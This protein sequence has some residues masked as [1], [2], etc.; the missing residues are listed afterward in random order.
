MLLQGYLDAPLSPPTDVRPAMKRQV[1]ISMKIYKFTDFLHI[2]LNL[3][4]IYIYIYIPITA[5]L[6]STS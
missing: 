3:I 1:C 6:L 5:N 2:Y 4:Y